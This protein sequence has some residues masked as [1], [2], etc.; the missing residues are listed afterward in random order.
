MDM[1]TA[2]KEATDDDVTVLSMMHEELRREYEIASKTESKMLSPNDMISRV[3]VVGWDGELVGWDML[4]LRVRASECA[5]EELKER[6]GGAYSVISATIPETG[7]SDDGTPESVMVTCRCTEGDDTGV[8]VSA[9]VGLSGKTP[10][11][12][13]NM[14]TV[15]SQKAGILNR[16]NAVISM[17]EGLYV[18][19]F[20]LEG[21]STLLNREDGTTV[22]TE[23]WWLYV[24]SNVAPSEIDKF[25][26]FVNQMLK[27][28]S[29]TAGNDVINV[30][31]T[32]ISC[33]ATDDA[34]EGKTFS[35]LAT[36]LATTNDHGSRYM[37]FDYVLRG[38]ATTT[39]PCMA[40]ALDGRLH[41]YSWDS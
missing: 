36:E 28:F 13:D 7:K 33:D 27:A 37:T 21:Y 16:L 30:D 35:E 12:A 20:A 26:E 18:G 5:M 8:A 2:N 19:D 24:N 29:D 25:V 39:T 10:A 31:V 34:M 17:N 15:R 9:T 6:Y 14:T 4:Q 22:R 3:S 32:V 23:T 11:V 38:E 41:P 1:L 40:E